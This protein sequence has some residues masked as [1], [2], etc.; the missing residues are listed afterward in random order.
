MI[1]YVVVRR[2]LQILLIKLMKFTGLLIL[3]VAV[4][5]LKF[6]HN[7]EMAD[8][9]FLTQGNT[10]PTNATNSNLNAANWIYGGMSDTDF[11]L[12]MFKMLTGVGNVVKCQ[13]EVPFFDGSKCINCHGETP[14]F[15]ID[16]KKC[17]NCPNGMEGHRCK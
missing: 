14:Y 15:N 4:N 1:S 8:L 16:T 13:L 9:N 10:H 3:L 7:Y 5:C 6:H 12:K 17:E 2:Y 11:K